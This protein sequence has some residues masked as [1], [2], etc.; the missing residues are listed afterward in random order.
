MLYDPKWEK[1]T[2]ADPFTLASVIAW[3]ETKDPAERYDWASPRT[4][5]CAQYFNIGDDWSHLHRKLENATGI[6]LDGLAI[7]TPWTF[8]ALLERVIAARSMPSPNHTK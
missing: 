2:K 8:G 1:P 3:L 5:A 4:C 7:K 6:R